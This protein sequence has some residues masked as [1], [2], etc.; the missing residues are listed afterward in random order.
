L[1]GGAPNLLAT[2][3][4]Y[5]N[6]ITTPFN[7]D[8]QYSP[9]LGFDQRY[10]L[11]SQ[12]GVVTA[13]FHIGT[14][15]LT[16]QTSYTRSLASY[17]GNYSFLPGNALLS[18]EPPDS[19]KQFT[20]EL[21]YSSSIGSRFDYIGGLFF[22]YSKYDTV[23]TESTDFPFGSTPLPFPI[24][25]A[26]STD[27]EQTDRAIS[28][29]GQSN[30]RFIDPLELV[31]GLRYT[32]ERKAADFARTIDVPGIYSLVLSPPVTPFS[33]SELKGSVDGSVGLNYKPT[34]N[35]LFYT[36][37][38]Q[39]TK[40]GGY[41][42]TVSD[43]EK[44]YY[45]PE[46]AQTAEVGFKTQFF[47]RTLTI[48]GDVFDTYVRSFQV[49][50]FDGVNFDV[51]NQNVRSTGFE[52]QLNWAPVHGLRFYWNNI[53]ADARDADSG[54]NVPYAPRWAGRVGGTYEH[55]VGGGLN[56]DLD[57][58]SDYRSKEISQAVLVG[59]PVPQVPPLAELH[60]LNV[61]VGLSDPAQGWEVHLIGQNL[62]DERT[63]GFNFGIPFV[64]SPPGTQNTAE[65][66]LPPRT[67]KLQFS[68]K[69]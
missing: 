52:S 65:Y 61:G 18:T 31:V 26:A 11:N 15:T 40:A 24:G 38:G 17:A 47:G 34:T 23:T 33:L 63:Y 22:L 27:F 32:N 56:A 29:F 66:P 46:V 28:A 30:Y 41:A 5:P 48:N 3:F 43:L 58:N 49:V 10:T 55:G 57:V 62:T 35:T 13:D 16:S 50:I 39:G 51:A 45:R 2:Y 21:R 6:V 4:G 44:S 69:R 53:Y 60:R 9:G 67:I 36:S 59:F 42:A 25:G 54:V 20:Q 1:Y 8:A 12:L 19:S 64:S 7:Q 68:F 37:W 14:G